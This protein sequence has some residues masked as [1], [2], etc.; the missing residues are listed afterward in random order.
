[1]KI[2]LYDTSFNDKEYDLESYDMDFI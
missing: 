1:M 2:N